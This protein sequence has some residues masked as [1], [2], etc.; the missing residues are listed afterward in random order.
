M[1]RFLSILARSRQ[2]GANR[3]A[4]GRKVIVVGAGFAGLAAARA[5]TDAGFDVQVLEARDRIGGRVDTVSAFGCPV[6]L[7]ASWLHG[8]PANPL[9]EIALR[10]GVATYESNYKNGF[11]YDFDGAGGCAPVPPLLRSGYRAFARA[12]TWPAL[13]HYARRA[14]KLSPSSLSIADLIPLAAKHCEAQALRAYAEV[15]EVYWAAPLN[16]LGA[17]LLLVQSRTRPQAPI[18]PRGELY[19]SDGMR[20]VLEA[21][22]QGL[23]ITLNAPVT[24]IEHDRRGARVSTALTTY[25]ADA[26][27]V[28]VP[29][30]VLRAEKIQ[31]EPALPAAHLRALRKLDMATMN[32]VILHFDRAFWPEEVDYFLCHGG[33]F[34]TFWNLQVYNGVPALLGLTGGDQGVRA[35]ALSDDELVACVRTELSRTFGTAV[36]E[37]TGRLIT[38][39]HSDPWALGSYSTLRP[40]ATGAEPNMLAQPAGPRLLIAGE[41][42]NASD[43]ATVHGAYWSGLRAAR[44]IAGRIAP[45]ASPLVSSFRDVVSHLR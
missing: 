9:K 36:P 32:K 28:T 43:R 17:A 44:T 21:V 23:S 34:S 20:R 10:A 16:Q 8:G 33:R 18:M 39:W 35:E 29:V 14:L 38:R 7:G 11:A 31:F 24:R 4:T 1:S 15:L 45:S 22:S 19:V 25:E 6:D 27:I 2:A 30:G 5:L 42:T 26:A 40:G 3:T 37:P 12:A 41:A 13:R